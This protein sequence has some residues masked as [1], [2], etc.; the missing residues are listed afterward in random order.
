LVA[1]SVTVRRLE[2]FPDDPGRNS[3][4]L[5]TP[6]DYIPYTHMT[7]EDE[8]VL[9]EKFVVSHDFKLM[10]APFAQWARDTRRAVCR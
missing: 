3:P 7:A 4:W 5:A 6:L 2:Q 8:R 1:A 9:T 10:V